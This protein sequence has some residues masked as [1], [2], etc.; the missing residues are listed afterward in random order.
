MSENFESQ[1]PEGQILIYQDGGLNLR[2]RL[3]GQT[4]WL[5]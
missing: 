1:A 5:S 2:V 4:V 3:E